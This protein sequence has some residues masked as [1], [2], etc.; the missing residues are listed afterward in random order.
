[1]FQLAQVAPDMFVLVMFIMVVIP[2]S[3]PGEVEILKD[4]EQ[5]WLC[6]PL[7]LIQEKLS[8]MEYQL[9]ISPFIVHNHLSQPQLNL[10]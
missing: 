10:T 1:M 2:L 5:E 6:V 4:G 9:I 7:N 3:I 8:G